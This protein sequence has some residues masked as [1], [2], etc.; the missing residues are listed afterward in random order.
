ML[1]LTITPRKLGTDDFVFT[2]QSNV[3]DVLL[4]EL[5]RR[6]FTI[7]PMPCHAWGCKTFRARKVRH[8]EPYGKRNRTRRTERRFK[9]A[10]QE[11]AL[12]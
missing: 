3:C 6:G 12:G 1:S 5:R 10:Q 9:L 11:A 2:V 8:G 7:T 4:P